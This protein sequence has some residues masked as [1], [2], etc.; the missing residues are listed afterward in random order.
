MDITYPLAK[1]TINDEDINALCDWLKGYPRLTKGALTW[2]VEED[3]AKYIGTS[4]SVFNNSGS[5]AN[6]LMVAAAIQCGRIANKKI[7][8]PSVGWVTTVAP[9]M[10]LGLEPI[11]CGADP[12][13]Y[14]MDLDQLET[15]CEEHNPDAVMFVQVLGIPHHKERLL[16]FYNQIHLIN[17]SLQFHK[18]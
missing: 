6:L 12:E 14:G 7:V 2:K 3:W 9:A 17:A 5:S 8:I 1:E 13:T 18:V 4:Y 10:Q 16:I 11:M 15:I